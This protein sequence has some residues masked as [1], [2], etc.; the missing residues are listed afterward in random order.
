MIP[1]VPPEVPRIAPEGKEG[2]GGRAETD[3]VEDARIALRER[4]EVVRQREDDVEVR[5]GQEVGL[6]RRQPPLFRQRLTLRTVTIAARIVRDA[7]GPAAVT[8]LPMPATRG[9]ATGGD[10]P[11]CP[12]LNR[13][14]P[15]RASIRLTMRAHNVGEFQP[16]DAGDRR[17][18]R[19]GAHGVSPARAA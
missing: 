8:R 5:N 13:D 1:I 12:L 11:K 14:Q 7:H 4:V 19:H 3:R 10:R 6:A 18:G 17:A 15:M 2:T 16:R 9:G